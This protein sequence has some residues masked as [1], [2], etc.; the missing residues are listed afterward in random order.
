MSTSSWFFTFRSLFLRPRKIESFTVS[1]SFFG[2]LLKA[3]SLRKTLF[4]ERTGF[5]VATF[6]GKEHRSGFF[7]NTDEKVLKKNEWL[8]KFDVTITFFTVTFNVFHWTS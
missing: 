3:C 4:R 8:L 6:T 7:K 2:S 1:F 5:E